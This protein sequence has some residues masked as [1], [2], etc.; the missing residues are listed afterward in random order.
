MN[1]ELGRTGEDLAVKFLMGKGY[2]VL[3]RNYRTAYGEIDIICEF[4][5]GLVLVEVK[6][7]RSHRFGLPQES[8]TPAKIRHLK[9]AAYLFLESFTKPFR[10]VRFDVIAITILNSENHIEHIESAF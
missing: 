10:F 6:T 7:R 5:G 2:K 3:K 9:K 1:Q 8:V 4:S